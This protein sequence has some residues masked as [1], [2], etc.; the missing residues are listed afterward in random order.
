MKKSRIQEIIREEIVNIVR[1]KQ[2]TESLDRKDYE[3][4]KDIIRAELAAVFFDLFKKRQM[5]I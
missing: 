3:E 2:L 1:E 5:W 4:I